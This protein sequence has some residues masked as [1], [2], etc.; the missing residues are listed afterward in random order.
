MF[1]ASSSLERLQLSSVEVL[2]D[3]Y[4]PTP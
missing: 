3:R 1:F 4:S 2:I